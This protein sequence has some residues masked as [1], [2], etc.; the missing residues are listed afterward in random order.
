MSVVEHLLEESPAARTVGS[1]YPEIGGVLSAIHLDTERGER[2]VHDFCVGHIIVDN[3][4][5]LLAASSAVGRFGSLLADVAGAV[6]LGAL[7]AVPQMVQRDALARQGGGGKFLG[8]NRVATSH[9]SETGC[10]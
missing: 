9:T 5:H 7:A 4:L 8:N 2:V 3:L 10:L 6:E 1:L